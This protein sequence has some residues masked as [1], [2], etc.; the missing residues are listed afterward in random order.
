L[1]GILQHLKHHE[2][3]STVAGKLTKTLSDSALLIKLCI[4]N[5]PILA[6][7]LVDSFFFHAFYSTNH[8]VVVVQ[9]KH[10]TDRWDI[11]DSAMPFSSFYHRLM[12][13][14]LQ[15]TVLF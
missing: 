2:D 6:P 13:H 10:H 3:K 12:I 8:R 5:G 1:S 9:G 15:I 14:D 7:P 4:V 11:P